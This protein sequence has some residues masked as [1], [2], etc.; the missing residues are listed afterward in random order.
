MFPWT[1]TDDTVMGIAVTQCLEINGQ[2]D[3]TDLAKRFAE[4]FVEDP[5]RGY[6]DTAQGILRSVANGT[7]WETASS[8]VFRG[9]GSMGNGAAMRVGPIGAWF[10]D[11][12]EKVAEQALL[13]SQVTHM[14]VEGQA[15]AIASDRRCGGDRLRLECEGHSRVWPKRL[16]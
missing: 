12:L 9:A 13:S 1:F 4:A 6:G 10:H 2:I 8:S 7:D 11:D 15:G 5:Y 16:S 3:Q 14:H